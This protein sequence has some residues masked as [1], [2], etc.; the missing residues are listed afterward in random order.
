MT[1]TSLNLSLP[2]PKLVEIQPERD[3]VIIF[4]Y[5]MLRRGLT[6]TPFE[7]YIDKRFTLDGGETHTARQTEIAH[8]IAI[9][10]QVITIVERTEAIGCALDVVATKFGH[11]FAAER[12]FQSVVKL[13]TV[14]HYLAFLIAKR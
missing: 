10:I 2:E 6:M 14:K 9:N 13:L 3:I 8:L 5:E 1:D 11:I 7:A 4:C 12:N